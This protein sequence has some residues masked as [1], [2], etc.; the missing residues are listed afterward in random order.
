[1]AITSGPVAP[2]DEILADAYNKLWKDLAT[3]GG[4][5][6]DG[7][8][9]TIDHADLGESGPISG[10]TYMHSEID[11]HIDAFD[12]VHGLA[13]GVAVAGALSNDLVIVAGSKSS[14]GSA[15]NI[16][17]SVNGD[18]PVGIYLSTVLAVILTI[19]DS[20]SVAYVVQRSG[21][22]L[23]SGYVS[24]KVF[25]PDEGTPVSPTAIDFVIV[26]TKV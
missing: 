23:P 25:R 2:G 8:G 6:H 19:N 24:Y 11:D 13:S 12:E 22:S 7:E 5:N 26:G 9:G 21:I 15:G 4:H 1:M 17:F 10:I 18:A 20:G 14:P 3:A 16:Y